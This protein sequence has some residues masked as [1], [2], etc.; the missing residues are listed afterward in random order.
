MDESFEKAFEQIKAGAEIPTVDP[1]LME[2]MWDAVSHIPASY[3]HSLVAVDRGV[4]ARC[5]PKSF[6]PEK[7]VAMLARY[8]LLN[9]LLKRGILDAFMDEESQRKKVFAAAATIPCDKNDLASE[10]LL[11]DMGPEQQDKAEPA[12]DDRD[13]L[14][15]AEKFIAWI[16]DIS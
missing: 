12:G 7:Q 2:N 3:Q 11:R 5:D 6:T 9:A 10:R 8:A 4:F 1:S 13:H 16:R 14:K 15:V